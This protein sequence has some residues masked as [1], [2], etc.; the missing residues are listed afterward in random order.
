M[1]KYI[2]IR[3]YLK[4][5]PTLQGLETIPTEYQYRNASFLEPINSTDLQS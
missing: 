5:L 3:C 1:M 2:N 4:Q